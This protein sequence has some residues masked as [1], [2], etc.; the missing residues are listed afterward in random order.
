MVSKLKKVI[1]RILN[2]LSIYFCHNKIRCR[3]TNTIIYGKNSKFKYCNIICQGEHNKIIFGDNCDICGLDMMLLE[4][5]NV[6]TIGESVII[7]AS[8]YQPTVINA[9]GG[10]TI[11]IGDGTGISH[12]VEMHTSDYHG[13]YDN[14]GKRI[15]YDKDIT[16][17]SHVFIGFGCKIM[18]GAVVPYG[19]MIG[20]DAVVSGKFTEENVILA[21]NPAKV[22]RNDIIWD[23]LREDHL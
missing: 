22:I 15:N 14:T 23:I 4:D 19:S 17:G 8:K 11:T 5:G 13:I 2:R 21:G 10:K 7:N 16:I 3:G 9:V 12:N 1:R 20:A 18:K 6:I